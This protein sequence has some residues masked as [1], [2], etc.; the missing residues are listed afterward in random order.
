MPIMNTWT[1]ANAEAQQS[2]ETYTSYFQGN[3]AI[4]LSASPSVAQ[5]DLDLLGLAYARHPSTH[6]EDYLVIPPFR[7]VLNNRHKVS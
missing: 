6:N 7:P 3:D 2:L 5:V 4:A 1:D